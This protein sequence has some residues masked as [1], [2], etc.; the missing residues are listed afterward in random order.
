MATKRSDS[1]GWRRGARGI[2]TNDGWDFCK[3]DQ[4]DLHSQFGRSWDS[5]SL[6]KKDFEAMDCSY[7]GK[8]DT[9]VY[10]SRILKSARQGN[11]PI[12]PSDDVASGL[13]KYASKRTAPY[14]RRHK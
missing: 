2:D 12:S 7:S 4:S 8:A 9:S 6:S 10:N 3:T 13:G 1:D 14:G 11:M 5:S